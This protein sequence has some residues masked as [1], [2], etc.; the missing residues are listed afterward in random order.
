MRL[1][2]CRSGLCKGLPGLEWLWGHGVPGKEVSVA[3]PPTA[4]SHHPRLVKSKAV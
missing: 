4:G 2:A 1:L 3:T